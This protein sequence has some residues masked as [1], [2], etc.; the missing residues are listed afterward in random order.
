MASLAKR[1]Q[2]KEDAAARMLSAA[3]RQ[4]VW[5]RQRMDGSYAMLSTM[6]AVQQLKLVAIAKRAGTFADARVAT[7]IIPLKTA[8]R[9]RLHV[10]RW[11]RIRI[12]IQQ[13]LQWW[14]P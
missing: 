3:S 8:S 11:E 13:F 9:D 12:L 6:A 14:F 4:A 1:T 10:P 2:A 7:R 5:A